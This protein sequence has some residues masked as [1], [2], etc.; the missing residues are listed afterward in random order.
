[1][2]LQIQELVFR[3]TQLTGAI[4]ESKQRTSSFLVNSE[5]W[6]RVQDSKVP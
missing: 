3:D 6:G 4:I 1:M 2:I 5:L